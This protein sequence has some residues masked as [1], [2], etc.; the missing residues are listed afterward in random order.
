MLALAGCAPSA[1]ESTGPPASAGATEEPEEQSHGFVEGAEELTEAQ[2]SIASIGVDGSVHLLNLLTAESTDLGSVADPSW[3]VSDGRFVFAGAASGPTQIIDTGVWTVPHGD[4]VHYYRAAPGT[5]G[6]LAESGP[7]RVSSSEGIATLSYAAT[8]TTVVLD[9]LSLGQGEMTE[10]TRIASSPHAAA[11][12]P[13]GDAVVASTV[14]AAGGVP[15]LTPYSLDGQALGTGLECPDLSAV[16]ETS[17]GATFACSDGLVFAAEPDA[18]AADATPVLTR[19]EYPATDGAGAAPPTSLDSRPHR[20]AV[21]GPAGDGGI[22]LA[23]SRTQELQFIPTPAPTLTAVAVGDDSNRVI[24][25][26]SQGTLLVI[27]GESGEVTG[28]Q[29]GLVGTPESAASIHLS[30]DTSRAYLS[31]TGSSALHEIDYKDGAR[32]ARTLDLP[33]APAFAFETGN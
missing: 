17:L 8:G 11:A 23:S 28:T 1:P 24:A 19:V 16:H 31:G 29:A 18:E 10:L 9:R 25:V 13:I 33:T 22:W 3:A 12:A 14:D 7:A 30:V 2:S 26:D 27:D 21:A 20:P 5:A 6:E 15:V 4:H 32:V